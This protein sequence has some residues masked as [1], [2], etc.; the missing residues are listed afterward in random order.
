MSNIFTANELLLRLVELAESQ[1]KLQNQ[2]PEKHTVDSFKLAE[3]QDGGSEQ[4]TITSFELSESQA[5]EQTQNSE[6]HAI[7]MTSPIS[8]SQVHATSTM[9]TVEANAPNCRCG[10]PAVR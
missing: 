1:D 2:S 6:Q 7:A 5:E 10:V 9:P 4:H 3:S 8:S